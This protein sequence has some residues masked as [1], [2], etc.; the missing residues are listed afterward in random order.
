MFQTRVQ[1]W[2]DYC[3]SI[4][5]NEAFKD[6]YVHLQT[7]GVKSAVSGAVVINVRFF[8]SPSHLWEEEVMWSQMSHLWTKHSC[9]NQEGSV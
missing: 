5:K 4:P 9:H 7:R 1:D 8:F 2:P 3:M 6:T